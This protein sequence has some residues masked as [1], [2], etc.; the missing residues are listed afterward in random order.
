MEDLEDKKQNG[1]FGGQS[2]SMEDI[3]QI[4]GHLSPMLSTWAMAGRPDVWSF[5]L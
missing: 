3:L 2:G 5:I 4:G 1:G